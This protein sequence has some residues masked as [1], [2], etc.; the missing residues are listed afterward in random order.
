MA[1][2]KSAA[3]GNVKS[4][5]ELLGNKNSK[6]DEKAPEASAQALNDK[7][8]NKVQ[9]ATSQPSPATVLKSPQSIDIQLVSD[10]DD[11]IFNQM[12]DLE[13][14]TAILNLELKKE[15][16]KSDIE[17][18]KAVQEKAKEEEKARQE[19]KK[20]KAQAWENEEKRKLL[21][22]QQK[23]KNL[24]I[25]YEQERQES[26]LKNYKNKMLEQSQDMIA[27]REDMFQEIAKL[28]EE[29]E[30]L[31]NDFKGRF[32]QLTKIA[33]QV[34]SDAIRV[35]DSYAK[36]VS[37]L[38]T[39]ISILNARLE[40]NDKKN[41]FAENSNAAEDAEEKN[42]NTQLQSFENSLYQRR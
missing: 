27:S 5:A 39:Q 33:D 21:Q 41:P 31:I 2:K 17:S 15:R 20:R 29:R 23:L 11:S 26:I 35:R 40:A 30:A 3:K 19:E 18:L 14:Q 37:D 32:L 13:K 4:A 28:K 22:E 9:S 25:A 12:S 8:D 24:E 10:V 38:Q 7:K 6:K 36:T 42:A 34:T 1:A 16:V